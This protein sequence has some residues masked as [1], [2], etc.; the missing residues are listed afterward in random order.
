MFETLLFVT[1]VRGERG[2]N[3][4]APITAPG[5]QGK[6]MLRSVLL[7][8][9]DPLRFLNDVWLRHGDLVQFPI[10]RP[11]TYLVTDPQAVRSVLVTNA[12]HHSKQ[13]LQYSNLA[14]VTGNGLLTA[15]DPPW[16]EHRRVIQPAFHH[17]ALE[18]M[19]GQVTSAVEPFIQAWQPLRGGSLVDIDAAMMK[20]SL[21]VVA[22]AL[23]GARWHDQ[24]ARLTSSTVIALDAVV[25][26]ARNPLAPPVNW[27][28]PGN[29]RLR[30]SAADLD[31]AVET[32]LS[33]REKRIAG[34]ATGPDLVDLLLADSNSDDPHFD[35]R[36]IRD[37]LVTFLVAGHETVAS[38]LTWTWFLLASNPEAATTLR[39]ELDSVL[40]GRMP[41]FADL[42]SLPWTRAV[43]DETLRL[44][45]PA[46]VITRKSLID[47]QLAGIE[48]RSGSLLIM[49]PWLVHRH[50]SAWDDSGEFHPA[51]F[52]TRTSRPEPDYFPFGLGPRLCIGRDLALM[53]CTLILAAIAARFEFSLPAGTDS[54]A[55][56]SVTL[57]PAHGLRMLI[58]GRRR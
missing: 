18:G 54:A 40:G 24:S 33:G 12:R 25:A 30:R 51:R 9:R 50:T 43:I 23:F 14:L 35:R 28:T 53:E 27:P 45:P 44:Y 8:R 37:E 7:I 49:S 20:L 6:D 22:S 21:H 3:W 38:A 52:L 19:A 32:V 39:N 36:A 26:R 56:A 15:D 5:P 10:P 1:D 29:R 42:Q 11:A 57:R 48:V 47:Q 41:G 58:R 4:R 13:T 31:K 17:E 46:W 55:L 2:Q 16:R 34:A